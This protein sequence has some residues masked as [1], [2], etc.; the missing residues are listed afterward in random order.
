[1][2]KTSLFFILIFSVFFSFQNAFA[3]TVFSQ[4]GIGTNM[5]FTGNA[6]TDYNDYYF[7]GATLGN[8]PTSIFSVTVG[9]TSPNMIRIKRI[10]GASCVVI[11]SA[12]GGNGVGLLGSFGGGS[13]FHNNYFHTATISGDFCDYTNLDYAIVSG[14][15]ISSVEVGVGIASTVVLD[16]SNSN[17]GISINGS[18]DDSISGGV[19][20]QLCDTTCSSSFS[21][22]VDGISNQITPSS[23][24][25]I[26]Y[27]VTFT[28]TYNNA[29]GIYRTIIATTT[30]G[31]PSI[32]ASTSATI[33][34]GSGL[35]YTLP[36]IL[37]PN[38]T[39]EYTIILCD[40]GGTSC[41]TR[42]SPISFSTNALSAS[43]SP[44][45]WTAEACTW[46]DFS[47]WTGCLDNV[48]H[49]LFS[50]SAES[51]T[52]F[53]GLYAQFINKPPFG[54]VVAIQSAISNVNDTA[55]APFTLESMP[56]LNTYIFDPIRLAL[57]WVLWVAF[58]FVFYHR[59]KNIDL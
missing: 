54:Y 44:P 39:Y 46:T 24:S 4:L 5:T 20:F 21:S 14:D 27:N 16:G 38:Q 22:P 49:D 6:Y 37:S 8:P 34:T 19:A 30:T 28:G 33:A 57:I 51:L 32:Y 43:I 3:S 10:S 48:F 36:L 42:T 9:A 23:G 11:S 25:T 17:A 7:S 41:T 50:P 53:N 13:H 29:A 2:K 40:Y 18:G 31:S 15:L 59:L 58:A 12:N 56:I 55:S 52:Q 45:V 1:M 26:P 47:T 35:A